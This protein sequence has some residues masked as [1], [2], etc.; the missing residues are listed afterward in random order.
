MIDGIMGAFAED[1]P[2]RNY[3]VTFPFSPVSL[4][5][6]S[7][8]DQDAIRILTRLESIRLPKEHQHL[9][10]AKHQIRGEAFLWQSLQDLQCPDCSYTMPFF[11]TIC[12]N[13]A[14]PD[15]ST[16][17]Q[18]SMSFTQNL[19]SGV[20]PVPILFRRR[21][22]SDLRLTYRIRVNVPSFFKK[23]AFPRH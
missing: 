8:Y 5:A 7:P 14:G 20:S 1:F 3:P 19:A 6:V 4:K 22:T 16:N 10:G 18:G 9:R 21:R 17:Y 15:V 11:A 2:Y 12:D 13:A 23:N